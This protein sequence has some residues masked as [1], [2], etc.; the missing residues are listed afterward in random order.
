MAEV[1]K[2]PISGIW[3]TNY[4]LYGCSVQAAYVKYTYNSYMFYGLLLKLPM[5]SKWIT[6]YM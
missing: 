3:I 5:L 1:F 4:M 2:Q 6:H